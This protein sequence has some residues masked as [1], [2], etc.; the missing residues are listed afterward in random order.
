MAGII[1]ILRMLGMSYELQ[2][3]LEKHVTGNSVSTNGITR[4]WKLEILEGRSK[5]QYSS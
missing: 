5:D 3:R 2:D 4:E 1:S